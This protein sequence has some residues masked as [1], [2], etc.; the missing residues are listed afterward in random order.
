M[1]HRPPNDASTAANAAATGGAVGSAA[2]A[3]RDASYM[4]CARAVAALAI[5]A[6]LL[7]A[8]LPDDPAPVVS[9]L[10]LAVLVAGGLLLV[11]VVDPARGR[12][13]SAGMLRRRAI[14]E[15]G[16]DTV[17]VVSVVWLA[18]S[19]PRGSLW[20]LLILPILEAALRF[21]RRVS[22]TVLLVMAATYIAR[23]VWAAN[24]FEAATFSPATVVQRVGVLLVVGLTSGFLAS[25][26]TREAGRHRK[27]RAEAIR[28]AEML[29]VVAE[30]ARD[31]TSLDSEDVYR[32]LDVAFRRL[33]ILDI[34]VALLGDD[35]EWAVGSFVDEAPSER[36]GDL[37][38]TLAPEI[39]QARRPVTFGPRHLEGRLGLDN[40]LAGAV[41]VPI[42]VSD[43]T[44]TV[45]VVGQLVSD[46][47][48]GAI[49][50]LARQAAAVLAQADAHSEIRRLQQRLAYL[51]FHDSLT[52][53][54]NRAS[55]DHKLRTRHERRSADATGVAVLFID[56]DGFKTIND[57]L[58]HGAGDKTLEAVAKRIRTTVRPGDS[59]ARLGGDEFVV[60]LDRAADLP[61]ARA[62]AERIVEALSEPIRLGRHQ[63]TIGASIG[64]AFRDEVPEDPGQLIRLADRAMYEAKRTGR[65]R[66]VAIDDIDLG[67]RAER[68]AG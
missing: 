26:L 14:A 12:A 38:V 29:E 20:V 66:I 48:L 34:G 39:A 47:L 3:R 16:I 5:P 40:T 32:S 51:A 1:S 43:E 27:S 42:E 37:A 22:M 11:N 46:D 19:D 45:I 53:L 24:Q 54:P 56:L 44:R 28:R 57:T 7:S 41:G 33:G 15:L 9:P 23:D 61:G 58:G 21:G 25:Q 13:A 60:L 63:A 65:G 36:L 30:A 35:D 64:I 2:V 59:V 67:P 49:E 8:S 62:A 52:G 6:L 17:A 31:M 50:L 18:G 68:R 4:R 55:F 10:I